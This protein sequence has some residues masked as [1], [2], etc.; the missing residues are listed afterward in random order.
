MSGTT[1]EYTQKTLL[2]PNLRINE[3]QL[4]IMSQQLSY[5]KQS[6]DQLKVGCPPT[7]RAWMAT[8]CKQSGLM[9]NGG[10]K[11]K[12]L[13]LWG[14]NATI[15]Q[16]NPANRSVTMSEVFLPS[17]SRNHMDNIRVGNS[18][19]WKISIVRKTSMPKLETFSEMLERDSSSE[20]L[21]R[22][23]IQH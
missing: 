21:K 14:T 10:R 4:P 13:L 18:V 11:Y 22:M 19:R 5:L 20:N 8:S 16:K 23:N 3:L 9:Q 15:A 2:Q 1:P 17:T 6:W 7:D 12:I